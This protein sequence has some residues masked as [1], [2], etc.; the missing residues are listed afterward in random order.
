M[1]IISQNIIPMKIKDFEK[2]LSN[3]VYGSRDYYSL[4]IL[5]SGR[6]IDCRF[7][8]PLGHNE[9]SELIYKNLHMLEGRDFASCLRGD[10]STESD[11]AIHKLPIRIMQKYDMDII[12][13]LDMRDLVRLV[14]LGTE[15][16]VCNDMGFVKL[17]IA[18]KKKS[19]DASVPYPI[20]NKSITS[21]QLDTIDEISRIFSMDIYSEIRKKQAEAMRLSAMID[22]H[23]RH[24][25]IM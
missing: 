3:K 12:P 17:S 16:L 25:S 21:K 20:F 8:E 13:D 23:L 5:P 4:Y 11:V 24:Q 18:Q 1:S 2:L 14:I 22:R 9:V 19:V 7:P 15:D 6:V 10:I